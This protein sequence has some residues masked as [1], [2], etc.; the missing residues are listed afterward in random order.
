MNRD[1][2]MLVV[3]GQRV[4]GLTSL[5]WG[6][7]LEAL[8]A[9]CTI[10]AKVRGDVDPED[11]GIIENGP[12]ELYCGSEFLMSGEFE[13]IDR[14]EDPK[15]GLTFST[16]SR[17]LGAELV[18]SDVDLGEWEFKGMSPVEFA[19][20]I[21]AP[22]GLRVVDKS[23]GA[24]SEPV[25]LMALNPGDNGF[26]AL[27]HELRFVGCFSRVV[28][29]TIEIYRPSYEHTGFMITDPDPGSDAK[30]IATGGR[31]SFNMTERAAR[32]IVKSNQRYGGAPTLGEAEDPD[33]PK[34]SRLRVIVAEKASTD[35]QA[36]ARAKW[37]MTVARGRS[38]DCN[39]SVLGSGPEPGKVWR[40]GMLL[41]VRRRRLKINSDGLL[42][43]SVSVS[44]D[45]S[46]LRTQLGLKFPDAF[47]PEPR[48]A[49]VRRR[50][51]S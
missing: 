38:F 42:V 29:D 33:V 30:P 14:S 28:R 4:R 16:T 51:R 1:R 18:I 41:G 49:K 43:S 3:E 20:K 40:P 34:K 44:Q 2:L 7:D 22:H 26:A 5:S 32:Y 13:T 9:T 36:K 46:G 21:A 8:C 23:N 37:E 45:A 35:A 24:A 12:F 27:E 6:A 50:K 48:P 19:R 17:D 11:F 10:S 15:G 31:A 47:S 25:E 39:F